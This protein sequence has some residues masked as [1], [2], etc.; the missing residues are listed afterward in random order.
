MLHDFRSSL[1][2]TILKSLDEFTDFEV[3][4]TKRTFNLVVKF[5]WNVVAKADLLKVY[6]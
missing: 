5:H 3:L 1:T 4:Y 6:L 2:E